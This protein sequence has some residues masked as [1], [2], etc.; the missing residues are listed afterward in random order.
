ME[1]GRV[2]KVDGLKSTARA[3][4]GLRL[5]IIPC[6]SGSWNMLNPEPSCQ[7]IKVLQVELCSSVDARLSSSRHIS[8]RDFM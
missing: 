7:F 2:E 5:R 3:L 1:Q 8:F 6:G 4:G